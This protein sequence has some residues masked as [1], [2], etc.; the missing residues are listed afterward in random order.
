[1]ADY[2]H[3]HASRLNGISPTYSS[4]H[5]MRKR[6]LSTKHPAHARYAALWYEPW[7]SFAT[8]LADMGERPAGLTLE[9]KDN[10]LGYGPSNCIWA[11]RAAQSRNRPTTKLN[12]T[13]AL[14]IRASSE[15]PTELAR[16][17]QVCAATIH[18]ILKHKTYRGPT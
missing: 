18:N 1:M 10:A 14:E 9:R 13:L 3:G 8:F 2:R 12:Y 17:H 15:T 4:W 6:C 16:R 11:T 5:A 7:R